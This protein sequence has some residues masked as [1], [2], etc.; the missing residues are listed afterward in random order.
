MAWPVLITTSS[1][2]AGTV[3]P[4]TAAL[5]QLPDITVV[6]IVAS[7]LSMKMTEIVNRS[8]EIFFIVESF[9]FSGKKRCLFFRRSEDSM[10]IGFL[11]PLTIF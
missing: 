11:H 5:F 3:P 1:L 7:A 2:V 8:T 10:V 6:L 4:Q 9:K